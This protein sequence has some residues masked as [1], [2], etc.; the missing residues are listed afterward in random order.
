MG[1]VVTALAVDVGQGLELIPVVEDSS[2][3]PDGLARLTIL[4]MN[5]F[6]IDA[7]V[8][9][10]TE[11]RALAYDLKPRDIVGPFDLPIGS[12]RFSLY[13][14]QH[15]DQI[16]QSIQDPLALSNQLNYLMLLIPSP[17][18]VT[19]TE[20][21]M[22]SGVTRLLES[23]FSARFVN[24][25]SFP[26]ALTIDGKLQF[27]SLAVGAISEPVPISRL[28][29]TL[30]VQNEQGSTYFSNRLGP[31]ST[32]DEASTAKLFFL[33]DNSTP[34][35]RKFDVST[36]FQDPPTSAINAQIRLIHGL[37]RTRSL[38]LQVRPYRIR[39]V[40]DSQGRQSAQVIGEDELPWTTV[41]EVAQI[42]SAS[43]YVGRAPEVYQVRAV[44]SG[45]T[46]PIAA[47][48]T[49]QLLPGG[50]YDFAVL[51]SAVVGAAT[52]EVIQPIVQIGGIGSSEDS[53]TAVFEGVNATL[54]ALAP[55]TTATPTPASSPTA[56]R[57]PV[58][59]NTPRPTNTP[60][61][62][63][64]FVQLQPAPP[65]TTTGSLILSGQ[66]FA[67]GKA[68]RVT[69]DN[70]SNP[71]LSGS[72]GSD[73]SLAEVTIALPTAVAP[74][75]HTLKICV[76]CSSRG[77]NQVEYAVFIVADPNM[78]ATPTATP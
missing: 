21:V 54:T 61:V 47:P 20:A 17:S 16:L 39:I 52:I 7:N 6:L 68:F 67:P 2:P 45:S 19:T 33:V 9:F 38:V 42:G 73:G 66:N 74:G 60:A 65:N 71:L 72:V 77:F 50:I 58:P 23:D 29:T 44:V 55:Q 18:D 78:T 70:D 34:T 15:P 8:L 37:P 53:A 56:T 25:T 26:I 12:F 1:G 49:L 36:L 10:P 57:T 11:G 35:E 32:P 28:G 40:P 75:T 63:P 22:F 5:P 14:A 3:L 24:T 41:G 31:W 4:Q 48:L 64:P 76:D 46:D 62:L 69:V 27:S 13:D 59:T 51:P 30:T 43:S